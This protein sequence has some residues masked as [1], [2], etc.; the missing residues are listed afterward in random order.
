MASRQDI[1][2]GFAVKGWLK[3]LGWIATALMIACVA[4]MFVSP[5]LAQR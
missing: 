5:L 4:A 1:L 2:G 3:I